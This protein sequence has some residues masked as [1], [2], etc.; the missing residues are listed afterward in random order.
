MGEDVCGD[1]F[2]GVKKLRVTAKAAQHHVANDQQRPAIAED[3]HG[4]VQ[5]TPGAELGARVTAGHG[6][7]IIFSLAINK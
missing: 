3:F 6:E 7:S 5:G 1:V 2:V 4:S